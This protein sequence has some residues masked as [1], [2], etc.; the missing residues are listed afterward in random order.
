MTMRIDINQRDI[1]DIELA[2]MGI[3]NGGPKALTRAINKTL[4]GVRTDKTNEAGKILNMKKT[5]IRKAVKINKATWSNMSAKVS[6]K[7]KPV[8]LAKFKNTRQTRKGVSVLVK[9][10]G[11]RTILRHAFLAT[12]KSGHVGVF[13]RKDDTFVGYADSPKLTGA[14]YGALPEHYRLPIRELYGP[15]V[16]DILADE[17]VM[18]RIVKS[19]N[20][21]LQKNLDHEVSYLLT[22]ARGS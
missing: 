4:T 12:M 7:G 8:A 13:W 9:V 17:K 10:G 11:Q 6:R 19:A 18:A 14:A 22:Q 5:D 2:L 21:R 20:E 1:L 16:E 3:R 15:R